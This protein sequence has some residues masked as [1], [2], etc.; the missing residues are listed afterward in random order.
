MS[1]LAQ[2]ISAAGLADHILSERQLVRLLG[3]GD[4]RRYG[5]V[6]R[7]LKDGSLL[8]IKR[9]T[10]LL[11]PRYR[12][13]A[14]HPFT[15]AQSLL[16][17]SYISFESALAHHGWI[18]EAVF[19][20]ASASPARKTLHFET[21][22]FGAFDFHPLAIADYR[23]LTS[24]DRVPMGKLTAIVAQPLR[25]LMDLV[26]LRK[27]PWSGIEWLTDGLRIDEEQLFSL[28]RG[29]FSKLK[30]VY[31]HKSVNTFIEALESFVL[32]ARK[33]PPTHD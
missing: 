33:A 14:V 19:V 8:R 32:T 13:E 6:N 12:T 31:K 25:A 10:Y 24:V 30:A 4:A 27:E 15:I 18:P 26:A 23:F 16:P 7:A 1:S 3:G 11:G 21:P 28:R 29:D 17:G 9:G 5:L 22:D 20:T 2:Q